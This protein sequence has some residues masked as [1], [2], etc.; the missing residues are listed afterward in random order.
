MLQLDKAGERLL[1]SRG[2]VFLAAERRWEADASAEPGRE[3]TLPEALSWLQRDSGTPCRV[4]IG[5]I[6][7]REISEAEDALAE[8]VGFGVAALGLT[9]ICGGKGGAMA[10]ACR[11]V[12][13]A[14]GTSLGLLPDSDWS[15]ANPY[16][17]IPIATGL[18]VARNAV[19]ARASLCL[20]AVGG[21][22][23]TLSEIAF[24]LQFGR[25]VFA[26]SGAPEVEGVRAMADWAALEPALCNLV[27]AIEA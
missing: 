2:R 9:L 7:G 12:A 11:G 22:Y 19:I 18:G 10:A 16:V 1:D 4:P 25:P 14:G 27:L 3:V 6:G 5:L 20:I 13:R 23:G 24:G 17:S 15:A 8:E 21:G 26:L